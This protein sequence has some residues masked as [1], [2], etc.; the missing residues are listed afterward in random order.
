[1]CAGEPE[2]RVRVSAQLFPYK[3]MRLYKTR[4]NVSQ[5]ISVNKH[6]NPISGSMLPPFSTPVWCQA[7]HFPESPCSAA[8][9]FTLSRFGSAVRHVK[10][11]HPSLWKTLLS[12]YRSHI[13]KTLCKKWTFAYAV[14]AGSKIIIKKTYKHILVPCWS[15]SPPTYS[16][17]YL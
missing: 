9:I 1:M 6:V 14:H 3:Q 17:K 12:D 5:D 10:P 4:L 2:G 8:F 16:Y 7:L 15:C 13:H 11:S